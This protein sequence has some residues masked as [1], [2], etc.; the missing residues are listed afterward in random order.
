VVFTPF[1]SSI[2]SVCTRSHY[3]Y[4]SAK[5]PGV[6]RLREIRLW[7]AAGDAALDFDVDL[8]VSVKTRLKRRGSA[9]ISMLL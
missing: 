9:G 3:S 6:D 8:L 2:P 7:V 4:R 5:A 1:G